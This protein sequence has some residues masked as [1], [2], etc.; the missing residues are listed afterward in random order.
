MTRMTRMSAKVYDVYDLYDAFGRTNCLESH[1]N[2]WL[3]NG[4]VQVTW[5]QSVANY[6]PLTD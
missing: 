4:Y 1:L 6:F 2:H 3:S 5:N